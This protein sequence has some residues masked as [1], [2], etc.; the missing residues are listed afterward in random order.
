M[1]DS[2]TTSDFAQKVG[3]SWRS[4]RPIVDAHNLGTRLNGRWGFSEEDVARVKKIL[5]EGDAV[6]PA[7]TEEG[8]IDDHIGRVNKHWV[9]GD[10]TVYF[11][12][13]KQTRLIKIGYS[14]SI[15]QRLTDLRAANADELEVLFLVVAS[16]SLE[17]WLHKLF[18]EHHHHAEWFKPAPKIRRLA[19]DIRQFGQSDPLSK[20]GW[21]G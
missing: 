5:A 13:G 18:A 16:K 8:Y 14:Q 11:I 2:L 4:L 3:H 12:Q 6:E 1:A 9:L 20:I 17:Q 15:K 21:D 7:I 19:E 10:G